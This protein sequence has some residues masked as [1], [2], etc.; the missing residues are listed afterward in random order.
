MMR[1]HLLF[2]KVRELAQRRSTLQK[3][4]TANAREEKK[5]ETQLMKLGE[6]VTTLKYVSESQ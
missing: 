5:C 4:M 3:D 6:Q 2:F 1:H